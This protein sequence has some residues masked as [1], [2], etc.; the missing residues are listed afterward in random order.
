MSSPNNDWPA[1]CRIVWLG[2]GLVAVNELDARVNIEAGI[3]GPV[4]HEFQLPTFASIYTMLAYQGFSVIGTTHVVDMDEARGIRPP[5]FRACSTG[6]NVFRLSSVQQKW[7]EVSHA[8]IQRNEMAVMDIASRISSELTY[9]EMRLLNLAE[10]YG[11][12]LG[13]KANNRE[14]KEFVR[15]KD[16]NSSRVYLAIHALFWEQAVLRDYLAEFAA[17]FLYGF[18]KVTS[19]KNLLKRIE[20]SKWKNDEIAIELIRAGRDDHTGWLA[21]FSEY[22]NLFTHRVPMA[23]AAGVAY[24]TL[25]QMIIVDG[26]AV[27]QLYYPLPGDVRELSK[28]RSSGE[29]YKNM[30]EFIAISRKTPRRETEPDALSYLHATLSQL[31]LLAECLIQRSPIAP[32][33]IHITETDVVDQIQVLNGKMR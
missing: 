23:Q 29:F 5:K 16:M 2:G 13:N 32:E 28:R 6:D 18:D 11:A 19:F 9:C 25:D 7:R 26:K 30:E 14:V 17:K 4:C 33:E 20:K 27:P 3:N 22:R 10:A 31:G 24:A 21:T 1:V 15:F 12:Q 8:A